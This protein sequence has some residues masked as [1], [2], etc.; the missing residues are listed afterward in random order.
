MVYSIEYFRDAFRRTVLEQ[1]FASG[2]IMTFNIVAVIF[3]VLATLSGSKKHVSPRPLT[4]GL[5][6]VADS[7]DVADLFG[8][9]RDDAGIR[10]GA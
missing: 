10:V 3:T 2:L 9:E 8:C 6:I 7:T 1:T 4:R 5:P